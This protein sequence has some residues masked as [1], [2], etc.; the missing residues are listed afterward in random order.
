MTKLYS[1]LAHVYHEMYK[2]IFDYEKEFHFYD[3]L[4][5][6]Y[7]CRDLLEIGCGTGNL[8]P[9]FIKAGYKYTGIDLHNEMLQIARENYPETQF[10]QADMRDLHL[11]HNCE[12][13]IITGRSFCYMAAN[14][15]VMTAL[16]SIYRALKEK[17]ILIFDNFKADEILPNLKKKSCQE[18]ESGDTKYRRLNHTSLN[19]ETGWTWN[20]HAEYHIEKNKSQ[21]STIC[22]H[23]IF[24]YFHLSFQLF[25]SN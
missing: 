24:V 3:T 5:R 8:A 12:S 15:D 21:V 14:K 19:L 17:G 16:Q 22:C 25:F 9:Y 6:K 20:W 10:I 13:I 2:S 18:I 23:L 11:F 1:E 7:K 4:L